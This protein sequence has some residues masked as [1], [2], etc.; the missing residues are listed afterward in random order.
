[1]DRLPLQGTHVGSTDVLCGRNVSTRDGTVWEH[2][3]FDDLDTVPSGRST[4]HILQLSSDHRL[5]ACTSCAPFLHLGH[6]LDECDS[7]LLTV[8]TAHRVG[9]VTPEQGHGDRWAATLGAQD[10][11]GVWSLFCLC[12]HQHSAIHVFRFCALPGEMPRLATLVAHDVRSRI[13]LCIAGRHTW[14]T[15][16]IERHPGVTVCMWPRVLIPHSRRVASVRMHHSA[17]RGANPDLC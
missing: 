16:H 1:M 6:W 17:A 11:D 12:D 2:P 3:P 9:H 4:N 8:K 7:M 10:R 15:N 14:P 5:F 13:Q